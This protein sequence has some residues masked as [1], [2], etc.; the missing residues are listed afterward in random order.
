MRSALWL[1][2]ECQEGSMESMASP[3]PPRIWLRL[4]LVTPRRQPRRALVR[5][6][7][8]QVRDAMGTAPGGP[9]ELFAADLVPF[10]AHR[11]SWMRGH[12]GSETSRRLGGG[13]TCRGRGAFPTS[14]G[15]QG[16]PARRGPPVERFT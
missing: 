6:S 11:R 5:S 2:V 16:G 10:S 15:R 3:R 7:S 4:T 9:V 12:S 14:A 13:R 8:G 1:V